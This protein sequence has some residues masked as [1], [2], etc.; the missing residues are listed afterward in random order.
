MKTSDLTGTVKILLTRR[1]APE[2]WRRDGAQ[3]LR[4]VFQDAGY[5]TELEFC[6]EAG[7]IISWIEDSANPGDIVAVGGGDGTMNAVLDSICKSGAVLIPIPLGTAN[8]FARSL[9]LPDDPVQAA[10]AAI[11][12]QPAMLDIGRVNGESFVNAASIG[13][14]ADARKRINPDL[15]RWTGALSYAVANWQSWH[16]MDPLE[17]QLTCG[18]APEQEWK[19]RQLTVTNGQYFG[20][21]LRP[22]ENKRLDDGK[23]HVFAIRAD[24]DTLSGMDIAAELLF[25]SVDNSD[26]AITME[27]DDIH[28]RSD[29][30]HPVLADGEIISE[31]PAHF[32]LERAVLPVFAPT[33]FTGEGQKEGD[34]PDDDIIND[35]AIDARDLAMRLEAVR[36]I[37]RTAELKSLT[38]DQVNRL[39]DVYRQL[40]LALRPYGLPLSSPDP[41]LQSLEALRDRAMSWFV[42]DIDARLAQGLLKQTDMLAQQ[43][44]TLSLPKNIPSVAKPL[45]ALA[46]IVNNLK[47]ELS[48][49]SES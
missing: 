29:K 37:A 28:I 25:G 19:L 32:T 20:G 41:D 2:N 35:I 31:L 13:V 4:T 8:D 7:D 26:L 15:K 22:R 12:G 21:G 48:T 43:I 49:I 14:P 16:E 6:D 24:V 10:Q 30:N 33:T 45:E 46:R 1:K 42:D 17:L 27:C 3:A 5:Q 34:L 9:K 47:S 11:N 38:N 23:L 39:R 40:E 18:D 44:E 36:N